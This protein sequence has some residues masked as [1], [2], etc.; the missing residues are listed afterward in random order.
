[1]RPTREGRA[2]GRPEEQRVPRSEPRHVVDG[3]LAAD[4]G[5]PLDQVVDLGRGR[6]A[7]RSAALAIGRADGQRGRTPRGVDGAATSIISMPRMMPGGDDRGH[8]AF[9]LA[10]ESR[11]TAARARFRAAS[12]MR[13]VALGDDAEQA[14]RAVVR[15]RGRHPRCRDACRRAA[16]TS[17]IDAGPVGSQACLRAMHTT[18]IFRPLPPIEQAISERWVRRV[19]EAFVLDRLGGAEIGDAGLR[20]RDAVGEVDLRGCGEP[21]RTSKTASPSGRAPPDSEVPEPRGT[22]LMRCPGGSAGCGGDLRHG[23]GQHDDEGPGDRRSAHR[24]RK[25]AVADGVSTTL[26]LERW[27]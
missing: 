11:P 14:L 26:R 6:R 7:R 12:E 15:G 19:V 22:T 4:L 20:P 3:M 16:P 25:P 23:L 9:S 10:S 13:T 27:R 5:H 17:S 21:A 18:G 2:C 1:M 8:A 24:S